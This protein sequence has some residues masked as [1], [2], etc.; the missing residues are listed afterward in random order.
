[1]P[2]APDAKLNELARELRARGWR[3]EVVCRHCRLPRQYH[4]AGG[5]CPGAARRFEPGALLVWKEKVH[6]DKLIP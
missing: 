4:H 1:M 2:V 6:E 5:A 3:A